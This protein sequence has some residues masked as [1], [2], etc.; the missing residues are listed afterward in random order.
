MRKLLLAAALWL[1]PALA[2]AQPSPPPS[3]WVINGNQISY[4]GCVLV[5]VTASAGCK[6]SGTFSLHGLFLDPSTTAGATFNLA[7]G[8]A[9]TS[10]NNGDIWATSAGVFARIGGVTVGPFSGPNTA[11]FA[12][13][14]PLAVTFPGGVVTYA[15]NA[16][17]ITNTYL[18][19]GTFSNI[20]GV[21]TLGAGATGSGF[22]IALSASTV[23]GQL[24]SLA[25]LP[26]IL[27][28]TILGQTSAG[29][30]IALPINGCATALTW[31]L[32]VGFNCNTLAGSGTVAAGGGNVV[33]TSGGPG[34]LYVEQM[35]P[36]GRLTLVNPNGCD[37]QTDQVAQTT[38]YYSP[39]AGE[40]VPIYDGTNMELHQ[41]TSTTTDTVGLSVSLG[42]NW[43]ANT[44]YDWFVALNSGSPVLCAG[45]AYTNSSI[46]TS[47]RAAAGA[48]ALFKG[49]QTNS[50][51]MTCRYSN[52]ATLSVPANQATYVGTTMMGA[53]N[54]TID[55]RFGNSAPGG[56]AALL[57]VCNF[58]NRQL[59]RATVQDSNSSWTYA[60]TAYRSA[61]NGNT[62][63]GIVSC[64]ADVTISARYF[65]TV[66]ASSQFGGTGIGLNSSTALAT[67]ASGN[68]AFTTCTG[69]SAISSYGIFPSE[70]DE[71]L[72]LGFNEIIAIETGNAVTGATF[73]GGGLSQLSAFG[74]M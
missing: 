28:N 12:G 25:N 61:D 6:G 60:S 13:T 27:A 68:L 4:G 71:T 10:P 56:G 63:V 24:P 64:N 65:G 8:S 14:A 15:L 42:S 66:V 57:S 67:R 35:A 20:T 30:P 29:T 34:T 39:C 44:L 52:S 46:G 43:S 47:A 38:L 62:L 32:G 73:A 54:G 70:I 2:L 37:I 7:I 5:P 17:G 72:P 58:Y 16:G 18:A 33:P 50:G 31:T 45:P 40:W 36:G 22:T 49:L 53:S 11:S 41:F 74:E 1:L 3:P 23:T 26:S 48:L 55:L 19:A 21:G 59:T 9:P 51:T 69:C